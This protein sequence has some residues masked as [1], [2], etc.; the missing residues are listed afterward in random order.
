MANPDEE[1]ENQEE[2]YR[3]ELK[4]KAMEL[5]TQIYTSYINY[6]GPKEVRGNAEY[7]ENAVDDAEAIMHEVLKRDY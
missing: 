2:Q 6:L 3:L 5:A 4:F 1:K 7:K